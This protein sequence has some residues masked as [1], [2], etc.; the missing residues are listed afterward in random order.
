MERI[1]VQKAEGYVSRKDKSA[2]IP[3]YLRTVMVRSTYTRFS[4]IPPQ[5]QSLDAVMA[6]YVV[7]LLKSCQSHPNSLAVEC[8]RIKINISSTISNSPNVE[9][10]CTP[11]A[12]S[13]LNTS[14]RPNKTAFRFPFL[15]DNMLKFT[16]VFLHQ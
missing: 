12:T 10:S 15:Q 8:L 13:I 5:I 3:V 11:V 14:L 16:K 6:G 2:S 4:M 1:A 9:Q 7:K